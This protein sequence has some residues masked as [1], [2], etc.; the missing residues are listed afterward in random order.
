VAASAKAITGLMT[1]VVSIVHE[2][3]EEAAAGRE[4]ANDV[5]TALINAEHEGRRLTDEEISVAAMQFLSAGFETTA[6]AI[7]SAV[8][9]MC[10]HPG[11]R[12]R[13]EADWSLLDN[14]CEEILRFES[15]IEGTFRTANHPV[16]VAGER[17][18]ADAKVRVVYASANRDEARF[19]D[20]EVFRIDR[21]A[22]E[23]RSHIA[24]GHG[25]HACIGSALARAEL[26]IAL[27]TVL[28]RRTRTA[29]CPGSPCTPSAARSSRPPWTSCWSSP[30]RGTRR[31]ATSPSTAGPATRTSGSCS[32]PTRGAGPRYTYPAETSECCSCETPGTV[33][34][35]LL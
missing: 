2:R 10:T 21:P 35:D 4:P 17:L 30:A 11:E 13:L 15:P 12:A 20:A 1:F 6:T 18:P 16:T 24:F 19:P 31:A 32:T 5:L 3:R 34:D 26:R 33:I 28:T 14:A 8:V 27:R 9:L 25:S 7:G 22:V 23:L 29:S